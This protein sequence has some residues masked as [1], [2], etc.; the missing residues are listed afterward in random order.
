MPPEV[1]ITLIIAPGFAWQSAKFWQDANGRA[2][3]LARYWSHVNREKRNGG[4]C[5][6]WTGAKVTHGTFTSRLMC[7]RADSKGLRGTLNSSFMRGL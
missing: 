5:W 6:E 1:N 3:I 2:A 4:D 7:S